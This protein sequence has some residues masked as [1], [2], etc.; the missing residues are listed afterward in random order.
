MNTFRASRDYPQSALVI[1]LNIAEGSGDNLWA[2]GGLAEFFKSIK[3]PV[4]LRIGVE[5]DGAWNRGYEKKLSYI[6]AFRHFV[7]VLRDQGVKNVATVSQASASPLDDLNEG[8]H[9]DIGDWY[10]GDD[11]VDWIGMSWFLP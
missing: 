8:Q 7:D 2:A 1:G 4:Y 10:P 9:E 6:L 5:F 11:Y 3:K